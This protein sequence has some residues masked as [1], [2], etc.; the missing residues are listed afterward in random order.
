MIRQ[1][2][3]K[4]AVLSK[5][6]SFSLQALILYSQNLFPEI[7]EKRWQTKLAKRNSVLREVPTLEKKGYGRVKPS[8]ACIFIHLAQQR[9]KPSGEKPSSVSHTANFIYLKC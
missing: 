5:Y 3:A 8:I 1:N 2:L 4:P 6:V 7:Y 9:F